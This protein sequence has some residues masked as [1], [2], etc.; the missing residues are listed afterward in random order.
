MRTFLRFLYAGDL[1]TELMVPDAA[2]YL[3]EAGTLYGLTN[4][5]L[6][7]LCEACVMSAF[8]EKQVLQLFDAAWSLEVE[9]V[10]TL[11]LEFIV[12]HFEEVGKHAAFERLDKPQL[13]AILKSLADPV[14]ASLPRQQLAA[15]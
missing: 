1:V 9:P 6:R 8:N 2:M 4:Q 12:T 5:R 7:H 11:A 10:K 3:M 15:R 13:V 14:G